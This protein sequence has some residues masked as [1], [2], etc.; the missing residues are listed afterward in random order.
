MF[1]SYGVNMMF[2]GYCWFSTAQTPH[3]NG[4]TSLAYSP[5]MSLK[6]GNC[7]SNYPDPNMLSSDDTVDGDL[8]Q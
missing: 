8:I 4:I 1:E 5:T 7:C 6:L 2:G 3:C